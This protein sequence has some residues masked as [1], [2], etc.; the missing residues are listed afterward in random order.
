MAAKKNCGRWFQLSKRDDWETPL[1]IWRQIAAFLPPKSRIWQPFYYN[2]SCKAYME[3]LGHQVIH[4]DQDFFSSQPPP[5]YLL[6]DNPPFSKR[7]AILRHLVVTLD[8]PFIL[9]VPMSTL[10]TAYFHDLVAHANS[11]Q[12]FKVIIPHRRMRFGG[13]KSDPPFASVWLAYKCPFLAPPCQ[14]LLFI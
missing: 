14:Q 13:L 7:R 12:A 4:E 8:I 1:E 11:S 10:A 2:G 9:V 6:C 5:G 3:Q